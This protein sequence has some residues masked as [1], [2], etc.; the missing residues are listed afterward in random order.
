[1]KYVQCGS[2]YGGYANA[3]IYFTCICAVSYSIGNR[4]REHG[5]SM[6]YPKCVAIHEKCSKNQLFHR[7]PLK[8]VHE[9]DI[10]KQM[11]KATN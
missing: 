6:Q 7:T 8:K 5:P 1:M 11:N 3:V 10:S 9:F 2:R 4:A